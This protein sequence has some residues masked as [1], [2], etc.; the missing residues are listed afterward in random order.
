MTDDVR[1]DQPAA[2]APPVRA[3]F[4]KA[5]AAKVKANLELLLGKTVALQTGEPALVSREALAGK[6]PAPCLALGVR[7]SGAVDAT[8]HCFV[9]EPLLLAMICFAQLK[10]DE[11]AAERFAKDPKVGNDDRAGMKDVASFVM[12]ALGDFA[13]DTTGG[14]IV[15]SPSDPRL[16]DA[17]ADPGFGDADP[18]V[19]L[20]C[21]VTL[22]PAPPSTLAIAVP[23]L[24]ADAWVE[25]TAGAPSVFGAQAAPGSRNAAAPRNPDAPPSGAAPVGPLWVA[26]GEAIAQT[27]REAAGSAFPVR[28]FGSLAEL[29][30]ALD[31]GA[32][33][34][35]AIFQVGPASDWEIDVVAA[36]RRHPALASSRVVV[37]LD[38]PS[39]RQVVRCATLGFADVVPAGIEARELATRLQRGPRRR[40]GRRS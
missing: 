33:P 17:G 30:A 36:L 34:A 7:A 16:L 24:L 11:A 22:A 15:L 12:A 25:S 20:E 5:A 9:A 13:K 28:P 29:M 23:R 14:R 4:L 26:G 35:V 8:L 10:S 2:P 27:A 39:R 37:V 3:D 19:E 40:A 38:E 32:P 31:A 1:T 6:A 18:W 21:S